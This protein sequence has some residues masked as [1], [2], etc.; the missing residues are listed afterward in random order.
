MKTMS[1]EDLYQR[2]TTSDIALFDERGDVDYEIGHIPGAK[3]APLG[4][5]VFR[6]AR[7][8]NSDSLVVVS[9][10]EE[11]PIAFSAR[12]Q[13]PAAQCEL[14]QAH[15]MNRRVR[16]GAVR[17]PAPVPPIDLIFSAPP[18]LPARVAWWYRHR[19]GGGMFKPLEA[20]TVLYSGDELPS[21]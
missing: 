2:V 3:T 8:M 12:E 16:I 11:R 17:P 6:V 4:S 18:A 7:V 20:G 1:T 5:L 19:S 14:D 9:A 13:L 21:F 10:G 15:S